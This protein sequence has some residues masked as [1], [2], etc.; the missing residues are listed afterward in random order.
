MKKKVNEM[1]TWEWGK[2]HH[3]H[4]K[5]LFTFSFLIFVP[6]NYI[7]LGESDILTPK[8]IST[9]SSDTDSVKR[10]KVKIGN[11]LIDKKQA[12]IPLELAETVLGDPF[13]FANLQFGKA[14][15]KI[16][17]PRDRSLPKRTAY[18]YSNRLYTRFDP[19]LG[20]WV[21]DRVYPNG[22]FSDEDSYLISGS[23][24]P[25][26]WL[27]YPAIP[28]T[29]YKFSPAKKG[30]EQAKKIFE[31]FEKVK[32]DTPINISWSY[33]DMDQKPGLRTRKTRVENDISEADKYTLPK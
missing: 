1:T 4:M 31:T 23:V 29:R 8:H 17:D 13:K 10:D 33:I 28:P 6:L 15:F 12:V 19:V 22:D 5:T 14:E 9:A 18:K 2:F 24:I 25:G 3:K 26:E 7:C 27:G 11:E 30:L 16:G 20:C 32:E 21:I